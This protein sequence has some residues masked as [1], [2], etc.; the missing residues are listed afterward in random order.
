MLPVKLNAPPT[1]G[2]EKDPGVTAPGRELEVAG[3]LTEGG[4]SAFVPHD[5]R[6][7]A[8][9]MTTVSGEFDNKESLSVIKLSSLS[10]SAP[11]C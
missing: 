7:R 3:W 1:Q 9:S 2:Q 4:E 11:E 5:V 10:S 6:I 8:K